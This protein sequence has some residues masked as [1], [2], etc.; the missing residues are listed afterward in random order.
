MQHH[1]VDCVAERSARG[2]L[3]GAGLHH[4]VDPLE[5]GVGCEEVEVIARGIA[6]GGTGVSH[7]NHAL[8]RT[9]QL[10]FHHVFDSSQCSTP[11]IERNDRQTHRV[12]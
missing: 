10:L 12:L 2:V 3:G 5:A 7:G 8:Q 6:V 4:P 9:V 11:R 1:P